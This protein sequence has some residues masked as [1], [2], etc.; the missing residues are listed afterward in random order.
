MKRYQPFASGSQDHHSPGRGQAIAPTMDEPGKPLRRQS[1]G[2]PLWS[3]WSLALLPFSVPT[4]IRQQSLSRVK[5]NYV[6][7]RSIF[8]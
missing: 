7:K 4:V 5:V 3:P 1:R 8:L 2:A 6:E